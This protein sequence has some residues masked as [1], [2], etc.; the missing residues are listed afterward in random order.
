M[1]LKSLRRFC[2]S[3]SFNPKCAFFRK[4]QLKLMRINDMTYYKFE[5]VLEGLRI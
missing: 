3:N 5:A 4:Y 1:T 2:H